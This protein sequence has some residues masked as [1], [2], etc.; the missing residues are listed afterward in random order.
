MLLIPYIILTMIVKIT[1]V[2]TVEIIEIHD[3]YIKV[4]YLTCSF[5]MTVLLLYLE[6][7][8]QTS[9]R[10]VAWFPKICCMVSQYVVLCGQTLFTQVLTGN[11]LFV[12]PNPFCTGTYQLNGVWP[13]D[14]IVCV[15]VC[16]SVCLSVYACSCVCMCVFVCV[17]VCVCVSTP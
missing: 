3:Y 6:Q 7:F 16:V 10:C 1:Y 4:I 11:R 13:H 2:V 17:Y 9:C 15:C 5:I 12:W 8:Y 14:T